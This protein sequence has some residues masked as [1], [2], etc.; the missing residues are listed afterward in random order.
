MTLRRSPVQKDLLTF[1]NSIIRPAQWHYAVSHSF[2]L[3]V[4]RHSFV[5]NMARV[6]RL[7]QQTINRWRCDAHEV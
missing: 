1:L 4:F 7:L 3:S 5:N 2:G 6:P